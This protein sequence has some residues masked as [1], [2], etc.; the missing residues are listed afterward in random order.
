[1]TWLLHQENHKGLDFCAHVSLEKGER[2][3][4]ANLANQCL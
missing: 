4:L 2:T 1:M 3:A